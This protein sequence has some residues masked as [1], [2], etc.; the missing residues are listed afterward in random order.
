MRWFPHY[1]EAI[2][3]AAS[4]LLACILIA[5][6]AKG[7]RHHP[8][9]QLMMQRDTPTKSSWSRL[10]NYFAGS[11]L[12]PVPRLLDRIFFACSFLAIVFGYFEFLTHG[13]QLSQLLVLCISAV[14]LIVSRQFIW[15]GSLGSMLAILLSAAFGLDPI[16]LW[17]VTVFIVFSATLRGANVFSMSA[18]AAATS[19][20]S[21][22]IAYGFGASTHQALIFVAIALAVCGMGSAIYSY[23]RYRQEQDQRIRDAGMKRV[24]EINKRVSD[25]R[26]QIARDL[27]DLVGHEIAM[28]GIHLGV[29]EVHTPADATKVQESLAA[30]RANI[31]SVLAETQQILHVLRSDEVITDNSNLATPAL[32]GLP[33]LISTV[34]TAG[35][36]VNDRL[37]LVPPNL[38][39]EVSTAAYRIVQEAL[40]NAQRHGVDPV[41][42]RTEVTAEFLVI[43]IHNKKSA[44]QHIQ[45]GSGLG[46]VGMKERTESA[47]G[48]LLIEDKAQ[49][50][51]ITATLPLAGGLD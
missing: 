49:S 22:V 47:G 25:E 29:A 1:S 21:A 5:T 8:T 16:L 9:N 28:L 23:F 2:A 36:K 48:K 13:V 19:F 27:H 41:D 40:T 17:T 44:T 24:A 51:K 31:Q 6:T 20:S 45:E 30:A 26:L 46:L 35:L 32:D 10:S 42:V 11:H 4:G 12:E 7:C 38:N 39:P 18:L 50:F 43:T 34:Q 37:A 33:H 15:L 14:S 3:P